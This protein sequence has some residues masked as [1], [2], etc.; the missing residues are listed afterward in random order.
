MIS[1]VTEQSG[2]SDGIRDLS[3]DRTTHD[4]DDDD[5]IILILKS[6]Y[7]KISGLSYMLLCSVV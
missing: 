7:W 3:E 5:R 1:P 2:D 6:I 4:D